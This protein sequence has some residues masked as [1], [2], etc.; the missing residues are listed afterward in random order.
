MILTLPKHIILSNDDAASIS[1]CTTADNKVV[2]NIEKE[3][4]CNEPS[5]VNLRYY[6]RNHLDNVNVIMNETGNLHINGIL[7]N[8][9]VTIIV[10]ENSKY[11]IF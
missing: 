11:Y 1:G 4:D 2:K 10:V 5:V 6:L 9:R 8:V 3:N 7:R